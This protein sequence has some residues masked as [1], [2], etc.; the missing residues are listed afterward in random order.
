MPCSKTCISNIRTWVVVYLYLCGVMHA[1]SGVRRLSHGS[2]ILHGRDAY[3]WSMSQ[4]GGLWTLVSSPWH[5]PWE[6]NSDQDN[7]FTHSHSV[8]QL[9][10][11]LIAGWRLL[12]LHDCRKPHPDRHLD[13][14]YSCDADHLVLQLYC[15]VHLI[16]IVKVSGGALRFS[17]ISVC[18]QFYPKCEHY[19]AVYSWC[20]INLP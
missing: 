12:Y 16:T 7:L 1:L 9:L 8:L 2:H 13:Y 20:V 10:T 5:F 11:A 6:C 14:V 3:I 15:E 18:L 19:N 17:V 4:V